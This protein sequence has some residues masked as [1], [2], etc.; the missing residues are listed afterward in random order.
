MAASRRHAA[1]PPGQTTMQA[2][3][4]AALAKR[5]ERESGGQVTLPTGRAD[6]AEVATVV[7]ALERA[8]TEGR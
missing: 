5:I 8:R 3:Y 1:R 7:R 6:I 2:A 4:L